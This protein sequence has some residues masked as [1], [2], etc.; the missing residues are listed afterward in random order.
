MSDKPVKIKP[1]HIVI[2][3]PAAQIATSPKMLSKFENIN[4]KISP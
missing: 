3:K 4:L 1:S 2:K